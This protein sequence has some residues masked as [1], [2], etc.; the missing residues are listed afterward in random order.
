MAEA[1]PERPEVVVVLCD[2]RLLLD[3]LQWLRVARHQD[4]DGGGDAPEVDGVGGGDTPDGW[5]FHRP[6]SGGEGGGPLRLLAG[7]VVSNP[8]HQL[9]CGHALTDVPY[10]RLGPRRRC[11]SRRLVGGRADPA[12][13]VW[14]A[15]VGARFVLLSLY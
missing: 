1:G 4:L 9:L 11:V 12:D 2:R 6:A 15:A 13:P 3:G 7:C 5:L 10:L 14:L 8:G